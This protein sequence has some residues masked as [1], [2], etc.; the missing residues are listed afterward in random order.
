MAVKSNVSAVRSA[1][2][3]LLI[4]LPVPL[5][6]NDT[7]VIA[8]SVAMSQ[9]EV[10]IDPTSPLSPKTKMPY[11]LVLPLTLRSVPVVIEPVAWTPLVTSRPPEKELEP[12]LEE[13]M[14]PARVRVDEMLAVPPTSRVVLRVPPELTPRD[15][16]K[17]PVL[18]R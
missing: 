15:V 7:P 1:L 2:S 4:E 3:M 12:V 10:L 16:P 17:Y 11:R 14:T 6:S 8:P 5:A 9:S 18:H 13:V